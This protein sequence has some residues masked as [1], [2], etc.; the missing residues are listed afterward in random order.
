MYTRMRD[1]KNEPFSNLGAKTVKVTDKSASVTPAT[2]A[3][4]SV[5]TTRTASPTTL[6]E[7]IILNERGSRLVIRGRKRLT[8]V[9]PASGMMLG[10]R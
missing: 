6:I 7:E 10:S 8:L 9:R 5:E 4:P 2:P 1:K 3:T